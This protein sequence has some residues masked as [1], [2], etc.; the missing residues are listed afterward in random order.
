MALEIEKG[1]FKPAP[2][3]HQ[4][5]QRGRK[6][7]GMRTIVIGAGEAGRTLAR[8]LRRTPSYGLEPI[9][10]LDDNPRT[11]GAPGLPVL[12]RISELGAIAA[13][14]AIDV[15]IVAIPSLKPQSIRLMAEAASAAGVSVRYLPSFGAALERDARIADLRRLRID[16]LLGRQEVRVVRSA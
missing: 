1:E 9:G 13:A 6:G 2:E 3:W 16:S 15:A 7:A 5:R 12:G 4:Q 14:H 11:K 10:F 8:D